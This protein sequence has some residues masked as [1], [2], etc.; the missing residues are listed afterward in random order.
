MWRSR[1]VHVALL[2]CS[3][4]GMTR[5]PPSSPLMTLNE[6]QA[7]QQ[8]EHRPSAPPSAFSGCNVKQDE[9]TEAS[10][11]SVIGSLSPPAGAACCISYCLIPDPV[12]ACLL[13]VKS[14]T[15]IF[16]LL[17]MQLSRM[18]AWMLR[19]EIV[20]SLAA[21]AQQ[22][23]MTQAPLQTCHPTCTGRTETPNLFA[24]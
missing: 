19:W 14:N 11:T 5:T 15:C 21:Q 4:W 6:R 9:L 23:L 17:C 16:Q 24:A 20:A 12:F 3:C 7:W 18:P 13:S 10:D 22:R 1:R 8:C 2:I